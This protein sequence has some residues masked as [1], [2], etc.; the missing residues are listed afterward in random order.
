M[1][2]WVSGED[3]ASVRSAFQQTLDVRA[4]GPE[5]RTLADRHF[6]ETLVRIHRAGEGAPYTGLSDAEPEPLIRATDRAL[7]AGSTAELEHQLV[8]AVRAGL[9]ERFSKAKATRDFRPG[10]VAAGRNFVAAYVSLTHWVEA[11]DRAASTTGEHHGAAAYEVVHPAS[12]APGAHGEVEHGL[13]P[14]TGRL[15]QH[16]PWILTGLLAVIALVEGTL[17]VRRPRSATI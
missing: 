4:L 2:H 15:L 3:E 1:L 16:L 5:A 13:Q 7:E 8:E 17:L 9:A 11:V 14:H 6:F 10:D 12:H